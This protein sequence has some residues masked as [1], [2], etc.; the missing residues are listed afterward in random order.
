MALIKGMNKLRTLYDKYLLQ[1]RFS[2]FLLLFMA[3]VWFIVT[4]KLF[5]LYG[6]PI[7][8]LVALISVFN[9][10]NLWYIGIFALPLSIN[11]TEIAG[12]VSITLPTD[13]VCLGAIFLLLIKMIS[14]RKFDFAFYNHPIFLITV[15]YLIWMLI[16]CIPSEQPG[17]SLKFTAA[18]MWMF[19]G[20]FVV[21]LLVFRKMENM[22]YFFTLIGI[23]FALVVMT[24]IFLYIST[25]RNPFLLRF[26]PGPFFVDH[27]V[28]GAF[29]ATMI[30]MAVLF[31]FSKNFNANFRLISKGIL[32]F[33]L[34]GLFF[35]YS[36]GAW[37]S[38]FLGVSLMGAYVMRH[39]FK[40]LMI[41]L[42]LLGGIAG[43]LLWVNY[44][45]G[46]L[47]DQAVSRKNIYDHLRSVT[48]FRSDDS[49][50]ERI[51]RWRSAIEMGKE[52]PVFG[53]GPGTYMFQYG[54][55]Q[56]AGDRTLI[57]TNRGDNG[58]AHNEFFLAL[59][60]TGWPGGLLI[61]GV[62]AV[63]IIIGLRGFRRSG[64]NYHRLLYLGCTFGIIT[65]ALHAFVNNFMDQDKIGGIIFGMMAIITALD[66]YHR[67][68][69]GA[70][71]TEQV[72]SK[73]LLE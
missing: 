34:L 61:I 39:W 24:V 72:A 65:Y 42:I 59:S 73:K 13:L 30:P 9:F 66:L 18:F 58:T 49:N 52:R 22:V 16:C 29:S 14:E 31:A 60:E 10:R 47:S 35:S 21:S 53:F 41:P 69:E 23:A 56:R 55:F 38:M 68:I 45:P 12:G 36:R 32:F 33:L 7:L 11:L 3:V 26:N 19:G 15:A 70:E 48:N 17:V 46:A 43:Y 67:N 37:L 28:F 4:R 63:P 71:Y 64:N 1:F 50:A 62:F 6:I 27:T 51:N 5:I 25:G 2:A 44:D 54:D 20:F 40:K 8:L 57:S